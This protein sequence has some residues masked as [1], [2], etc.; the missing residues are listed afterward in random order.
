MDK[1][2]DKVTELFIGTE[3]PP[4]D[5]DVV[6]FIYSSPL[7][8]CFHHI[9]CYL[10]FL[11]L[12]KLERVSKKFYSLVEAFC[13]YKCKTLKDKVEAMFDNQMVLSSE[14][15]IR[16]QIED[17]YKG[18]FLNLLVRCKQL[19][20]L[21]RISATKCGIPWYRDLRYIF[22]EYDQKLKRDVV[23]LKTVC[24]LA[25]GYTFPA[26]KPGVYTAVLRM[27]IMHGVWP[28]YGNGTSI[29][30]EWV[31]SE[32]FHKKKTLL[33]AR[34]WGK[35]KGALRVGLGGSANRISTEWEA[36]N[37][38]P[39]SG[40]F[41]FCLV[42]LPISS[43]CDVKVIYSDW[44]ESWKSNIRWDYIQLKPYLHDI[45]YINP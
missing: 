43:C 18:P 21:R 40:W 25:L 33:K 1:I 39:D 29:T 28:S 24:L 15:R 13:K 36:G 3:P 27:D 19:L 22:P 34:D 14:M 16:E 45:S 6:P 20:S 31:D 26:V 10:A 38:D 23:R 8:D 4:E 37:Y 42:K 44:D 9:F 32:G 12:Y 7:H 2:C 30:F 35:L 41:D 5:I 11:D 17:E